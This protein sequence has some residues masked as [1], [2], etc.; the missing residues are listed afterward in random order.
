MDILRQLASQAE[1][2]EV[3]QVRKEA[4]RITFEAGRLKSSQVEE[5]AGMA[6]RVVKNGRIGFAASTDEGAQDKLIANALESAA[7]GEAT[8]IIFPGAQTA[9]KVTTY[10][11]RIVDL[12]VARM[13]EIGQQIV[14]LLRQA[15]PEAQIDVRLER[16]V[17]EE[18]LRNQAGADCRFKRSPLSIVA[19]LQRVKGDDVLILYDML[20]ATLWD[21]DY[22]APAR[23]IA[24]KLARAKTIVPLR[25]GKMPVLFAPEGL[26]ALGMPLMEGLD[27]K[28]VY[29]RTSPLAGKIGEKLFDEKL[30]V[31]DDATLDGRF[32]SAPY[33]D[34]GVP[35]RRTAL[36]EGGV[37]RSF[38]YDLKTAAL[39]GVESTGNGGRSLFAP[40]QPEPSNLI[41]SAG[42]TPLAEMIAGIQEGLIVEDVLGLGQGNIVSGAFSNPLALGFK[43]E[44]GQIVGRVK[45]VSIAGNVYDLLKNVAAVSRESEWVYASY[46]LPYLLLPEMNV[47][48]KG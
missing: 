19:S 24:E 43:I 46:R 41:F 47:V 1:Q 45:D 33:D 5:T 32:G 39:S 26:L 3:I 44:R 21:D 40:P 2:A 7:Y 10:D 29:K 30:G 13:V 4:T 38:I 42:Q 20:G 18:S 15:E 16:G 34:E 25:S 31:V 6:V 36:I 11:Q 48:S 9:P 8:P 17:Q 12:P 23:R 14:E 35:H 22:M 27:G 28:N 37:L